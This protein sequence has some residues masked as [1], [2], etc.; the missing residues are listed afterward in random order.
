MKYEINTLFD[1]MYLII[2]FVIILVEIIFTS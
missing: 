2:D 1:I